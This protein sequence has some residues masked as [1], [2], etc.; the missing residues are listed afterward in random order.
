MDYHHTS[1]P[2]TDDAKA[3][4]E[5]FP[6]A[7]LDDDIWLEDPVSDRDLYIHKQSQ[8]HYQC[9]YPCPYSLNLPHSTPED[10]PTPYYKMMDL[11]DI[12]DV[13]DVMTTTSD[14]DIPDLEAIFRL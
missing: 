8:L 6:T 11:S 3:E 7:P 2:S 5:N 14:E 10:T 1:T 9:S 13:Q 12:S 4:E